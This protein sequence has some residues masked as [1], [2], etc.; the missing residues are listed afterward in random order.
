MEDIIF[1]SDYSE[2]EQVIKSAKSLQ[3]EKDCGLIID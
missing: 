1:S 2:N 3:T